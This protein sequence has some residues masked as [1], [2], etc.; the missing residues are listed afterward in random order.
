MSDLIV[1][2]ETQH[3]AHFGDR[4][5]FPNLAAKAYVNHAGISAPS[6]AV[7]QAAAGVYADYEKRGVGAFLTWLLQRGRLKEKLAKLIGSKAGDIAFTQ[8]T[9]RGVIE[10]A[11][12]FP[13]KKGDRIVLLA[14]EFP[15]NV[16][17]WQRAA[18]L[19]GLEISFLS[20]ADYLHDPTLALATLHEFVSGARDSNR[21]PARLLAVSAVEFQT[22]FRMPIR[23]MAA[24]CNEVG[25]ELFVD[26][27]QACGI[28]PIDVA[29]EGI[30]YLA[31]GS[32][33]W[34]MGVEGC[35]FLYA[36]PEKAAALRPNTAGWLSHEDGLGFLFH[37]EGHLRYDRP[38]KKTID[39]IEGGN[40]NT[41]GFAAL[42]A[43]VDL[44]LQLGIKNIFA[45]ANSYNDELEKGLL[46]RGF[47]SLRST[48]PT[49]RSGSLC[50]KAPLGIST[51]DIH[52]DLQ[53]AGISCAVPDGNLRFSP[54]WPNSPAE[55]PL[56]LSQVEEVLTKHR[57]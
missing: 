3:K 20:T 1:A 56:I 51:L 53:E 48:D 15:A 18:E 49:Y 30:D 46:A 29:A 17:P 50:V 22:G 31:C 2:P 27:V 57:T 36:K 19:F 55:V 52:H 40:T 11:L 37:G 23:E 6:I 32:H 44:L 54:H 5:L 24:I 12:C 26:A 4:S 43:S 38:I 7:T 8:N 42:E 33:K 21:T 47:S 25:T 45:H 41:A 39:F 13:W 34:L 35:G 10:I 28:V 14:G 9:T 16:T